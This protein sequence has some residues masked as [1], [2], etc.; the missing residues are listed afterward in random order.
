MQEAK[1]EKPTSIKVLQWVYLLITVMSGIL[2]T[3]FVYLSF[4]G[5]S[6]EY[7]G[8]AIA[9]LFLGGVLLVFTFAFTILTHALYKFE[10][11]SLRW[12]SAI[13]LLFSV[14]AFLLDSILGV[15]LF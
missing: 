1:L 15:I 6:E 5:F 13:I 8:A 10:N 12:V 2:A 3:L 11:T 7:E 4:Q 9:Y 14:I